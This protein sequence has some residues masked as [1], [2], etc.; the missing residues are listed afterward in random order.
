MHEFAVIDVTLAND[1]LLFPLMSSK[2]IWIFI[3]LTNIWN[4][5]ASSILCIKLGYENGSAGVRAVQIN[6]YI[7]SSAR[8]WSEF[9]PCQ[10][11]FKTLGVSSEQGQGRPSLLG[12]YFSVR[13]QITKYKSILKYEKWDHV[14]WEGIFLEIMV[15]LIPKW[16]KE[17]VR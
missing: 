16:E 8:T 7:H 14:V 11:L 2:F 3:Y 15:C 12:F 6:N 1:T 17:L 10:A 9:L 4:L 13:K 5:T